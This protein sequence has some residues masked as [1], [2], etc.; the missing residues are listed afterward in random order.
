MAEEKTYTKEEL[1]KKLSDKER[2]FCHEYIIDWNK[3]RAARVAGYSE[4][5]AKDIGYQ[6][7]TK[8]YIRQYIDL[9]KDDIEKESGI[10]K[11][12]QLNELAKIAYSN[13]AQLHD[14]WIELTDWEIIKSNNPEAMAAIESID[15]K[16]EYKTYNPGESSETDV[17]VK[18]I[19]IKLYS[20]TAALAEINKMMGYNEPKRVDL[21]SSDGSMSPITKEEANKISQDLENEC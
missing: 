7:S 8:L 19:K 21:S 10:T 5:S 13:I 12:R 20:K 9:I 2:I 4:N 11:L 14:T 3:A 1:L 6:V 15:T 17:E 16:T 18:Y